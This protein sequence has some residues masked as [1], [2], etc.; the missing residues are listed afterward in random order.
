M[1]IPTFNRTRQVQAALRSVLAQT[2]AEFEVIVVDDGSE[3]GTGQALQT[4]ISPRGLQRQA[5]PLLLPA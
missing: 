2:Y 5:S 3:D 1:I 4:L